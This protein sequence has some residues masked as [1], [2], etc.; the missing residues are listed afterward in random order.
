MKAVVLTK[1]LVYT[2]YA[3]TETQNMKDCPITL[4]TRVAMTK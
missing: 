1:E 3:K 4:I 2:M